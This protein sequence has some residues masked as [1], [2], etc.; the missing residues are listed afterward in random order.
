MV[1]CDCL[2]CSTIATWKQAFVIDDKATI[3]NL[4]KGHH[5]VLRFRVP[6]GQPLNEDV[7]KWLLIR[8]SNFRKVVKYDV[9]VSLRN[10]AKKAVKNK[11]I[12]EEGIIN[13]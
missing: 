2:N 5:D 7:L 6:V 11:R 12:D 4:C 1:K 10:I 9:F 8:P 13:G 3:V